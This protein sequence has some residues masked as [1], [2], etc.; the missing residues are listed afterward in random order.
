M[1]CSQSSKHFSNSCKICSKSLSRFKCRKSFE[2]ITM[3]W[4]NCLTV[5]LPL[6]NEFKFFDAKTFDN[7][8]FGFILHSYFHFF[9]LGTNIIELWPLFR[10]Q[11]SQVVP[12]T[13]EQS[14][15]CMIY[16]ENLNQMVSACIECALK[17]RKIFNLVAKKQQFQRRMIWLLGGEVISNPIRCSNLTWVG[18]SS[19]NDNLTRS[20]LFITKG[21]ECIFLTLF[22]FC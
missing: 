18:Y 7:F 16:N 6:W 2:S 5:P 22:L 11:D 12:H 20:P 10:D 14:I 15:S 1:K 3:I 19:K 4:I 17:V 9:L 8:I 13:H 21:I